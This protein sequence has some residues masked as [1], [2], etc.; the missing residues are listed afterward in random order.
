MNDI[1]CNHLLAEQGPVCYL[2]W[3]TALDCIGCCSYDWHPEPTERHWDVWREIKTSGGVTC[4]A[5]DNNLGRQVSH[6]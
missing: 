6:D 4:N 5:A 3:N 1:P 2:G